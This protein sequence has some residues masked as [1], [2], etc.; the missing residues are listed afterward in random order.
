MKNIGMDIKVI[1]AG[2]ANLFRSRIF[3]EVFVNTCNVE[4]EI[5]NTDGSQGAARGAGIGAGIFT[6]VSAFNG[7]T[8]VEKLSP[9]EKLSAAYK[10]IYNYW[11]ENLRI[12]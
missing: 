9:D 7:L 2:D 12:E 4:L 11:L 5:Y 3:K 8:L 6:P 10:N 1:K